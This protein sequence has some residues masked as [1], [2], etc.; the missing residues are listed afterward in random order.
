MD[1]AGARDRAG[2]RVGSR[3][4]STDS[5][6]VVIR[7]PVGDVDPLATLPEE[8]KRSLTDSPRWLPSK[9]HY[10]ARGSEIFEEI[11]R[12][13]EYYPTRTELGILEVVS[14]AIV[15]EAKPQTLIEYG[16]GSASKTRAILDAMRRAG[17][18][19]GYGAI[20][21]SEAALR[22]SAEV[23][24]ARY[25]GMRFEGVVADFENDV[26]LPFEGLPRLIL[27]L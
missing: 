10:D 22:G 2:P 24:L 17:R 9:F 12:L 7:R 18:L 15:E 11:T 5:D 1:A 27:F 4:L 16:S 8:V 25:P 6:R 13:P 21:V 20:E 26:E 3:P 23:L 19:V 14:D